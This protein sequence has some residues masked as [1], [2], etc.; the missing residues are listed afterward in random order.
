MG[1]QSRDKTGSVRVEGVFVCAECGSKR[2]ETHFE[3]YVFSYGHGSSKVSL[4][5]QVPVRRC[6]DCGFTYRDSVADS[7][8][9]DAI[10]EHLGVMKPQQIKSLREMHDLTQA[11]FAEL[12]KLGEAT[13]SRWERGVLIQ[14]E[15]YD[16]Y[17][18]LL[19]YSD[20]LG[21]LRHRNNDEPILCS[22]S[23]PAPN[24]T[25]LTRQI[26]EGFP[27]FK[28]KGVYAR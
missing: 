12:T 26:P 4:S 11:E 21:R 23:D 5:A 14:T 17:L 9:H 18:Y 6:Q 10:C 20:N 13:I 2:V 15:A 8:C 1:R 22:G 19:G 16:N 24:A 27:A 28:C 3:D 25:C 7:I